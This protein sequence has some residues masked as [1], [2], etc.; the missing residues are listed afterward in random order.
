[1]SENLERN[2]IVKSLQDELDR[3]DR[4]YPDDSE[5]D[6]CAKCLEK[7]EV[8]TRFTPDLVD[9]SRYSHVQDDFYIETLSNTLDEVNAK[10]RNDLIVARDCLENRKEI[11]REAIDSL[12]EGKHKRL[13]T[14]KNSTKKYLMQS[15]FFCF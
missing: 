5:S 10:I 8:Y 13:G 1:M 15:V 14:E 3:I 4:K 7:L 2:K 11:E 6:N 9:S 12:V